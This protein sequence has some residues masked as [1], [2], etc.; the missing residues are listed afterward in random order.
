MFYQLIM[1]THAAV[2]L[3]FSKSAMLAFLLFFWP[4]K[5]IIL[6]ITHLMWRKSF[7]LKRKPWPVIAAEHAILQFGFFISLMKK[8]NPRTPQ[9]PELSAVFAVLWCV[10]RMR[11]TGSIPGLCV[12][13]EF[14]WTVGRGKTTQITQTR[15]TTC[16]LVLI[17]RSKLLQG[18]CVESR[19]C[20]ALPQSPFFS[21]KGSSCS[22]LKP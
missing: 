18:V 10:L 3:D 6:S 22:F 8:T 2:S 12:M 7:D 20:F 13:L 5:D 16:F 19:V 14:S 1:N 15:A 17:A 9:N 11:V 4:H 21:N